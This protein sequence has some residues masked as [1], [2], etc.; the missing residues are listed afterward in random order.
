[1]NIRRVK[2]KMSP[3]DDWNIGYLIR[4][5]IGDSKTLLDCNF[6]Y[7]PKII[8]EGKECLAYDIKDDYEKY[9]NIAITI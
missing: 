5:Y 7:V 2:Y 8:K 3:E 6:E 1:M 9:L 4:N